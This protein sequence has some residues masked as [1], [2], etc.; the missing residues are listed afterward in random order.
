MIKYVQNERGFTLLEIVIVLAIFMVIST[1]VLYMSA[2]K[3]TDYTNEQIINQTELLI[4]LAQTRAIETKSSYRFY[5]FNCREV[6]VRSN[7]NNGEILFAQTLPKGMK[8]YVSNASKKIVFS[9]NGNINNAGSIIY[10]LNDTAYK[11][12]LNI[13]K[14]RMILKSEQ[15]ISSGDVTCGYDVSASDFVFSH[16]NNDSTDI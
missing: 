3:F 1:A 14:G 8:I 11:F 13:G 4:R 15:K 16:D 6:F 12:S 5:T 9:P 10:F 7:D 2:D